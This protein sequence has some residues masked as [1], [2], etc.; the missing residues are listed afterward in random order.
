MFTSEESEAASLVETFLVNAKTS[1]RSNPDNLHLQ[2]IFLHEKL[3]SGSVVGVARIP[4]AKHS[5][6]SAY[7][8]ALK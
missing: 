1:L 8:A 3:V 5:S 7:A 4:I 6:T 2:Y